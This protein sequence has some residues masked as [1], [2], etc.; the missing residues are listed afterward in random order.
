MDYLRCSIPENRDPVPP[1]GQDP[2]RDSGSRNRI[3]QNKRGPS[4]KVILE[5]TEM[6]EL[7]I[8]SGLSLKDA[9]E[10]LTSINRKSAAG[11]LGRRLSGLI[12]KGSSFAQ[13][14]CLLED[15]FSPI[16]RGMI[17]VGDKAGSVESI[18]PRLSSY[19]RDQKKLG[20]KISA[21]LAY[22]LLVL[23]VAVFGGLGLV[24]FVIPKLEA[25]FSGFAGD[26]A[27]RIRANI[28][29]METLFLTLLVLSALFAAAFLLVKKLGKVNEGFACFR[30]ALLFRIPLLGG[31]LAAWESLNFTFAMEVLTGGGVSVETAIEEASAVITNQAYSRA[32]KRVREKLINGG[33]ISSAFSGERVFPVYMSRWIAVGERS[34]KTEKIF[35]RIRLYFQ[36][37]IERQTAKLL[38]LIEPAL[39]AAVGIVMLA[40]VTGII[41]PLFSIYGNII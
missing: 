17:K 32:L 1:F 5:F 12:R 29:G 31:F 38:L 40:M 9:L 28:N 14:I 24:F 27:E 3:W 39:I 2:A 13:A 6:M 26:A 16:Y 7:L 8:E 20:D 41:L 23:G 34:G 18:F 25:L 37:E 35:S 4:K 36:G 15:T 19:L 10:L 21:A 33:S 30:D 11:L 22:P